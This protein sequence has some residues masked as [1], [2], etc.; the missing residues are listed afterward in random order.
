[1]DD[2]FFLN[3]HHSSREERKHMEKRVAPLEIK[4]KITKEGWIELIQSDRRPE[5]AVSICIHIDQVESV[6]GWL[7]EAKATLRGGNAAVKVKKLTGV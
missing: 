3:P 1:L 4:V 5:D 6:I 2:L 7:K